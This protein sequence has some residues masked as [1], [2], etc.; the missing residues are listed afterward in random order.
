MMLFQ[1]AKVYPHVYSKSLPA[2]KL[3]CRCHVGITGTARRVG[4]AGDEE[5]PVYEIQ[6]DVH[7]ELNG[8][9]VALAPGEFR[10]PIGLMEGA[11][12]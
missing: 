3:M 8:E 1:P 6:S 2:I 10:Q 7:P 9:R 5:F 12:V 4:F 11:M